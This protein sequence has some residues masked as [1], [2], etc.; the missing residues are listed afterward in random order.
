MARVV[1]ELQRFQSPYAL[2]EVP[3]LQAYLAQ[4]LDTLKMGQ[5]AQSL[6]QFTRFPPPS[7]ITCADPE[8]V[9]LLADRQ[10]LVI[11]PRQGETPSSSAAS[12][13]SSHSSHR[14]GRELL[15]WRG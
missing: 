12:F 10:S 14:P 11:E 5:D 13:V 15:N 7:R 3:E 6:C 8:A 1:G 4:E 2:V 9:R